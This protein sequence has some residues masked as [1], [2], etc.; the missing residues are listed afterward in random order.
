MT[1]KKRS[2]NDLVPISSSPPPMKLAR[3]GGISFLA[4]GAKAAV[5]SKPV[6]S[7]PK[8]TSELRS[9]LLKESK[10]LYK[11]PPLMPILNVSVSQEKSTVDRVPTRKSNGDFQFTDHEGVFA[12][13]RSPE[14]ILRAGA[15]GGTY[16]R[17]LTS[18]V[19]NLSYN[20]MDVVKD[21]IPSDWIKGLSMPRSLV[22]SQYRTEVNKFRVKC[23]GSLGMWES[24]GWISESDPYGW[25]QW[26][27]RFFQGRRCSDD[28]RQ[29]ARWNKCAGDRGRFRSQLSN[30]C[31]AANKKADD[32]SISPV[33]R[34]TLL[35]W[36]FELTE[37]KLKKHAKAQGKKR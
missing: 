14:E 3:A 23:G 30:K 32:S 19:T 4:L 10:E 35:H 15:F 21:T 28:N 16:F 13:N 24:S 18:A 5:L 25:F 26:Y 17:S 31:L 29:I 9:R 36:G 12:P 37:D 2:A 33:I 1:T 20:G 7:V 6:A 22:S 8:N 27:C 11:D 34:Q